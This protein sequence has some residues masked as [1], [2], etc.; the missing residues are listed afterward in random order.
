MLHEHLPLRIKTWRPA[1]S[2]RRCDLRLPDEAHTLDDL[3]LRSHSEVD[4]HRGQT[5]P[6][7]TSTRSRHVG[8][9]TT[10][11]LVRP[12]DY[13]IFVAGISYTPLQV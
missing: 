12:S 1:N 6:L 2:S 3:N 7:S 5:G 8:I 10:R 4:R 9:R 11:E 13:L